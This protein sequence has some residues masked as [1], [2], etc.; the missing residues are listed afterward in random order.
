MF[1]VR[2]SKGN[3]TA[4]SYEMALVIHQCFGGMIVELA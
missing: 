1:I 4:F 2:T 3:F